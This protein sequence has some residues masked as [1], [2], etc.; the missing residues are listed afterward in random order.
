MVFSARF[1][2]LLIDQSH[3]K[4]SAK[5]GNNE[6]FFTFTSLSPSPSLPKSEICCKW[7]CL[8]RIWTHRSFLNYFIIFYRKS[9]IIDFSNIRST[10]FARSITLLYLFLICRCRE[11]QNINHI[12][13]LPPNIS[14]AYISKEV[15]FIFNLFNK[16]SWLILLLTPNFDI[17]MSHVWVNSSS[18]FRND[19]YFKANIQYNGSIGIGWNFPYYN[20]F[21]N[22]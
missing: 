9:K 6:Q 13:F 10:L 14:C 18:F 8:R 19:Q 2:I 20:I 21:N 16:I 5:N 17:K 1:K 22:G 7:I 3:T 4:E 15:I 12:C 11:M